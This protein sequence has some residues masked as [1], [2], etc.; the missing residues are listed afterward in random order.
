MVCILLI[1]RRKSISF[2]RSWRAVHVAAYRSSW[3][4]GPCR[5]IEVGV[6]GGPS[7][8]HREELAEELA[9]DFITF[10]PAPS[11]APPDVVGRPLKDAADQLARAGFIADWGYH[12]ALGDEPQAV[13]DATVTSQ[14]PPE[15]DG[16]VRL[17]V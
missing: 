7:I 6:Y 8:S 15:A 14:Q 2:S 5:W 9:T 1:P 16:V 10:D 3:P 11:G 12:P 13:P 4:D 17:E